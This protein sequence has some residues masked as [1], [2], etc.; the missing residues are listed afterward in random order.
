MSIES[1]NTLY[2]QMVT[3]EELRVLVSKTA[4]PF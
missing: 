3:D 1:A 4:E 2:L